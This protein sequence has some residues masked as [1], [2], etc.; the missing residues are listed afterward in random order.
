MLFLKMLKDDTV[1]L[2]AEDTITEETL[3]SLMFDEDT[4]SINISGREVYGAP[5]LDI[6]DMLYNMEITDIVQIA[7][8]GCR[9]YT[10][11]VIF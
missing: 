10:Y 8:H 1:S 2:N 9:Y 11:A 7:Q 3:Q 4:Y 6:M 5:A